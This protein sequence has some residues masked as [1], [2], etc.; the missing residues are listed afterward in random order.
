MNEYILQEKLASIG[1]CCSFEFVFVLQ[2]HLSYIFYR[3]TQASSNQAP[4]TNIVE[5][6]LDL[7]DLISLF[8]VCFVV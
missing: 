6:D 1:K 4:D 7:N 8:W 5:A 3:L 2:S